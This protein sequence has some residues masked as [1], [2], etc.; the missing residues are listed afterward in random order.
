MNTEDIEWLHIVA[1]KEK[2]VPGDK[3]PLYLIFGSA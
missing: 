2:A 3:N 1:H